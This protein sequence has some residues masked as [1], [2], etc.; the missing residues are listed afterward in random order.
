[1]TLATTTS[2]QD[3]GLL[4]ALVPLFRGQTGIEVQVVAVG[5]GQA[6]ELGRRGDADV[7]LVHDPAAEEKFMAE[8]HGSRRRPV[9]HNDFILVGPAADLAG[10]KGQKS[11]V[12]AFA[13]V[14]RSGAPFVS[15]GDESGTHALELALWRR[16]KVEPRGAWYLQ[17][18]AGM[19]QVLRLAGEKRAYALTDRGTFLAQRRGLGLVV[20]CEGDPMLLNRYSVILVS[21]DKHPHVRREPAQRFADFLL[22]PEAQGVIAGFGKDRFGEPLF[23]PG[24]AG[25]AGE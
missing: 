9:M 6:L 16:A 22:S 7:L 24:A 4:D 3:S 8:G 23:F 11:A 1:V 21:P 10:V 18:G 13:Q 25:P 14:A 15:R 19:G 12:A 20:L 17:A 2:T 5:T